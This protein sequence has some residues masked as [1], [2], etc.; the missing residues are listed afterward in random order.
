MP[1][2]RGRTRCA[3]ATSCCR[4][5]ASS[6]MSAAGRAFPTCRASARSTTS[7][8]RRS[9]SSMR[10]LGIWSWSEAA[11]SA[12]NSRRCTAASAREVTV[13]EKG[14]RLIAREDEDVS[15]AIRDI[16]AAEG[17]AVRTECHLHRLQAACGRRRGRCRL[18][19]RRSVRG[20][21]ACAA[22]RRTPAQHRRSRS[23]QG[24][25]DNGCARLHRRR[26]VACDERARHL[27]ARRLQRPRRLHAHGLQRLRD[28]RRQPARRRRR[29]AS[30]SGSSAMRSTST[31]RSAAS[32]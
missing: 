11:I 19:L 9:F 5:R 27:G 16:L 18:H 8:T 24:R 13:V 10:F 12:S 6:S 26:R 31:R 23:R 1:A 21:L 32:A 25:R 22:R 15:E 7:P 30:A 20:R 14:P 28:R 3:S 2:S 4:R 29:A 17:I